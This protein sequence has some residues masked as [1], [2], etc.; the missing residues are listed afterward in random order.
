MN[1]GDTFFS[2]VSEEIFNSLVVFS[3]EL[4]NGVRPHL[5]VISSTLDLVS[6]LFLSVVKIVLGVLEF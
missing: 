2:Q 3:I 4:I 6:E 1:L 5:V